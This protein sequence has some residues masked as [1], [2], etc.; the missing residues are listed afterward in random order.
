VDELVVDRGDVLAVATSVNWA[1]KFIDIGAVLAGKPALNNHVVVVHHQTDGVWWGVEGK[2]GGVGWA[3][4]RGYLRD[5][6]TTSNVA[7]PKT[8]ADR[9]AITA[10]AETLLGRPYDWEAIADDALRDLHLP[11]WF[12]QDWKPSG[13]PGHVVCSSFAAW[14]YDQRGLVR[15]TGTARYIQPADWTKFNLARGWE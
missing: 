10:Y 2:P 14:L 8:E 9:A 12:A 6:R 11:T 4:I 7:Q 3:D 15:P 5:P 13:V 1:A